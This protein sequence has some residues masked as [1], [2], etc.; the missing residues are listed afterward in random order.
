MMKQ[1][2]GFCPLVRLELP[3][4]TRRKYTNNTL[5]RIRS[6]FRQSLN[7]I[8]DVVTCLMFAFLTR[9]IDTGKG[10][11]DRDDVFGSG[12]TF[13]M[14]TS[15]CFGRIFKATMWLKR[16]G[17]GRDEERTKL[18]GGTDGRYTW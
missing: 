9:R 13:G 2:S 10:A 18:L 7:T 14:C 12:V 15:P 11:V 16:A 8:N 5:P 1:C 4:L 6:E 17:K 3:C